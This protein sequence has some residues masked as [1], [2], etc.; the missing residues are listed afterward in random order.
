MLIA[1][2]MLRH[3]SANELT[4]WLVTSTSC[5]PDITLYLVAEQDYTP[6]SLNKDDTYKHNQYQVGTH[7]FIHPLITHQGDKITFKAD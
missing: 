6:L 5:Q 1:G 7:A 4:I 2:P 3:V